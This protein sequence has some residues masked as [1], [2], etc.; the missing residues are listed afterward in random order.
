MFSAGGARA[1]TASPRARV[2]VR[3][4]VVMPRARRQ[5]RKRLF[6][7]CSVLLLLIVGKKEGASGDAHCHG[8]IARLQ[9]PGGGPERTTGPFAKWLLGFRKAEG[10]CC[11]GPVTPARLPDPLGYCGSRAG[12]AESGPGF[13]CAAPIVSGRARS[14]SA[15]ARPPSVRAGDHSGGLKVVIECCLSAG[16]GAT[17]ASAS[18]VPQGL[19][20]A[21]GQG[22]GTAL[23][24]GRGSPGH[25]PEVTS[26]IWPELGVRSSAAYF[27]LTGRGQAC[28]P[29]RTSGGKE[30]SWSRARPCQ[31]LD[32]RPAAQ[33]ILAPS[34]EEAGGQ[35]YRVRAGRGH[36]QS[37]APTLSHR[38]AVDPSG[39]ACGSLG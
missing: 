10:K 11:L 32:S 33:H 34:R 9:G 16:G 23:E 8:F 5:L 15:P 28:P 13:L 6:L 25:V 18:G 14:P 27:T 17:R 3:G 2:S 39:P 38:V 30:G 12:G 29:G 19:P 26:R 21:L 22:C 20:A 35:G 4:V 24:P 1:R 7:I 36:I 31:A 37:P